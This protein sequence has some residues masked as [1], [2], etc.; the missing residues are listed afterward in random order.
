MF[1]SRIEALIKSHPHF[2][3]VTVIGNTSFKDVKASK[4]YFYHST[5]F[6]KAQLM[7]GTDT[8]AG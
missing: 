8:S 2:L 4:V 6:S 5:Q 7:T 3:Y 1:S